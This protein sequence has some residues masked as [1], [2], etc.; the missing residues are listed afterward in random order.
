MRLEFNAIR[1]QNENDGETTMGI[2]NCS[3]IRIALSAGQ[4]CPPG[5]S[6]LSTGQS[7]CP[8]PK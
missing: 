8:W 2:Q 4:K 3:M 5:Q 7:F 1:E 6:T